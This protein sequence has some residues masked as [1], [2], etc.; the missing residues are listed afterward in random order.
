MIDISRMQSGIKGL[1]TLL[2]GGFVEKDAILISGAPGTGKSTLGLEFLVN[3]CE[4]YDEPGIYIS[5]EEFPQQL[6][7]DAKGF[8]WDLKKLENE[9]KLSIFFT[10]PA[11]LM[12]DLQNSQGIIAEMVFSM[13]A[14]RIVID[15]I[16]AFSRYAEDAPT[17]RE[18]IY[19]LI[20]AIKREGLTALLLREQQEK[21]EGYSGEEYACDTH[22][23]LDAIT[24]DGKLNRKLK[25]TKSRG[26][27]SIL[28]ESYFFITDNGI[29]VVVPF[30]KSISHYQSA[31]STGNREFDYILGSGLPLNSFYLFS[32]SGTN[33]VYP[34]FK[35]NMIKHHL[36]NEQVVIEFLTSE[37]QYKSLME[38]PNLPESQAMLTKSYQCGDILSVAMPK[39]LEDLEEFD[40]VMHMA[41]EGVPVFLDLSYLSVYVHD[42]S[43]F[44]TILNKVL[45]TV[46]RHKSILVGNVSLNAPAEL[47]EVLV[48]IADGSIKI[49]TESG[50]TYLKVEKSL[51]RIVSLPY[52]IVDDI[53]ITFKT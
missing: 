21:T 26:S 34:T 11:V 36:A 49:W 52:F 4:K 50:A 1:D 29:D 42:K 16:T 25:V 10:S 14:K 30:R 3:G 47:L 2:N 20:N 19:M 6:Y 39:R 48:N 18:M 9:N 33:Q 12:E 27:D 37:A 8:G 24:V 23:Y 40:N 51:N 38:N 7:R 53:D 28:A 13:N 46:W 17:F 35:Q 5:F 44:L 41:G 22:I 45:E 43:L 15:S 32:L 31:V